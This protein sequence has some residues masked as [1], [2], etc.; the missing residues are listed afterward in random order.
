LLEVAS[1]V[2]AEVAP[3]AFTRAFTKFTLALK[4]ALA[5]ED[6]LAMEDAIWLN[7]PD[8]I[9]FAAAFPTTALVARITRHTACRTIAPIAGRQ[10]HQLRNPRLNL[11]QWLCVPKTQTRT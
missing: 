3:R 6:A 5:L 11:T 8:V 2:L 1:A 7:M 10:L 4:D 9:W